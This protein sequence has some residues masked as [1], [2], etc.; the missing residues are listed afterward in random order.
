MLSTERDEMPE[1]YC[2]VR[3]YSLFYLTEARGV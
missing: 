3:V 2:I 1:M